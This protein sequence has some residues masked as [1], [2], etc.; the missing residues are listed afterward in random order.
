MKFGKYWKTVI[1]KLPIKLQ[2]KTLDYKKWKKI[3][4]N[5][6]N[7]I[8]ELT[9][10]CNIVNDILIKN[11][12]KNSLFICINKEEKHDKNEL[13]NYALLNKDTIYK[14]CKKLDK[15]FNCEYYKS[16]LQKNYNK[17]LFNNGIYYKKLSLECNKESLSSCPICLEN[18]NE[19]KPSIITD[20]GHILCYD[21]ILLMYNIS[22]KRGTINNLMKN[23][24]LHKTKICPICR[25]SIFINKISSINVYPVKF[26]SILYEINH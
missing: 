10:E 26:K 5:N 21:C 17:F 2:S 11:V 6:E 12:K 3:K 4:I 14:I 20:C 8:F 22:N 18:L 23:N 25:S 19:N 16:W 13:Y 7:L 1:E 24:N 9:K 15:K